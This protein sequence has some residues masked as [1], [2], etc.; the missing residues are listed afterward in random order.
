MILLMNYG[1]CLMSQNHMSQSPVLVFEF[2]NNTFGKA[3]QFVCDAE[4]YRFRNLTDF[5]TPAASKFGI[6]RKMLYLCSV[7]HERRKSGKRPPDVAGRNRI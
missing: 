4:M 3:I 7:N 6:E 2:A 1:R 5:H